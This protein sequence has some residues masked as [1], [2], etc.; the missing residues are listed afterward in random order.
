MS[1]LDSCEC[2]LESNLEEFKGVEGGEFFVMEVVKKFCVLNI[3]DK[4]R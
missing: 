2:D 1:N 3:Y 4:V